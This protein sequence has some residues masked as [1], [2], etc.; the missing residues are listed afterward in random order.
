MMAVN[1]EEFQAIQSK[2]VPTILQRMGASSKTP[3]VIQHGPLDYSGLEII[4]LATEY[5]IETI[6][7][8]RH[9]QSTP[10]PRLIIRY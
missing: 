8:I 1:K 9:S 6:Q 10:S 4:D 3:T 7:S 5:G 2:A